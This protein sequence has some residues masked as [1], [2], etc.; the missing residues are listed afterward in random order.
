M[1]KVLWFSRHEMSVE[2]KAA[3]G[4]NIEILQVNKTINSARELSSEI[5]ECDIIA[6]VA[7]IGL[8]AEFLRLAGNKPVITA[9]SDRVFVKAEDGTE[10]KV[11][12]VFNR[13]ERLL[14]IEVIK[15]T[16]IPE[17]A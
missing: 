15:E 14:K 9:V 1:K 10:D 2:Q 16:F 8:Q 11:Q 12:F 6:I 7:P 5:E 17:E 4:N 3:L 13:W